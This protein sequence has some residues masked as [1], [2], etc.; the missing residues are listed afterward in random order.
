MYGSACIQYINDCYLLFREFLA[1]PHLADLVALVIPAWRTVST[2][3]FAL[4]SSAFTTTF[5]LFLHRFFTFTVGD[6]R[7]VGTGLEG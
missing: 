6:R 2:V 7:G 3:V 5:A 4:T 1:A